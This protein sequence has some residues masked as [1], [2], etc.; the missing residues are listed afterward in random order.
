MARRKSQRVGKQERLEAFHRKLRRARRARSF[1]EAYGLICRAM[2][3]VEDAMSDV[4]FAPFNSA[5]RERMYPPLWDN[6]ARDPSNKSVRRLR[7]FKHATLIG[8][9]GSISIYD[10]TSNNRIF[11][12]AGEDGRMVEEV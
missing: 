7:S 9:N 12:K 10:L 5:G 11:Q 2:N 4:A 1:D 6:I 8:D 3:E